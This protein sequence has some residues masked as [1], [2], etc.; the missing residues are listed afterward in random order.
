MKNRQLNLPRARKL[1]L[2][3][4]ILITLW[5]VSNWETTNNSI[6]LN[7]SF[8]YYLKGVTNS[9]QTL[10]NKA[11]D[12]INII[13][14]ISNEHKYGVHLLVLEALRQG[15]IDLAHE[16][17]LQES[18]NEIN[19]LNMVVVGI[20]LW[21]QGRYSE[22]EHLL[23]NSIQTNTNSFQAILSAIGAQEENLISLPINNQT[24]ELIN[25]LGQY[26]LHQDEHLSPDLLTEIGRVL[27]LSFGDLDQAK[28]WFLNAYKIFPDDAGILFHLYS[29]TIDENKYSEALPYLNKLAVRPN[30]NIWIKEHEIY[31]GRG[32][33]YISLNNLNGAIIE[34][35]KAVKM[36]PNSSYAHL[37]LGDA[38]HAA[39]KDKEA[40]DEF[41]K[42][43]MLD[44]EPGVD[45]ESIREL[46]NSIR[47]S[48]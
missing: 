19:S 44:H 25:K 23:V 33:I 48:S 3:G 27:L 36:A 9:N 38:Y 4:F 35:E 12:Q 31:L 46:L 16:I 45:F 10:V 14:L 39:N 15:Q 37:R 21:N 1:F 40:I 28:S 29:I 41:E 13:N 30:R 32:G 5:V 47:Q 43:L 42:V 26:E 24:K 17:L 34:F 22:A 20:K 8:L 7:L 2:F 6:R 11:I 18:N